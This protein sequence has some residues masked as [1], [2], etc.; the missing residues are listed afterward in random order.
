MKSNFLIKLLLIKYK[1]HFNIIIKYH[2]GFYTENYLLVM[3]LYA[4][5]SLAHS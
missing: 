3:K 5:N 4:Y 2:Q 1:V